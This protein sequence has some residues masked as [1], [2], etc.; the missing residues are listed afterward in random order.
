M[1][2]TA[3]MDTEVSDV[4]LLNA[5]LAKLRTP[6]IEMLVRLEQFWNAVPISV[7]LAGRT[8]FFGLPWILVMVVP[9]MANHM[10]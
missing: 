10:G 7:T 8:T 2:V 4:Q 9:E 6:G 1:L 5:L 3:G